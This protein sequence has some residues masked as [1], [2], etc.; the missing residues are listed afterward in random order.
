M[1]TR[2]IIAKKT[3]EGF[4]GTY[5]HWDGYPSVV[6]Q[7][8]AEGFKNGGWDYLNTVL[9]H[10]WSALW[11]NECHCCGTMSDGRREEIFPYTHETDCGAEYA[12]VFEHDT[13]KNTDFMH[14][15]QKKDSDGEHVVEFFGMTNEEGEWEISKTIDLRL[16]L[17]DFQELE[18]SLWET[19]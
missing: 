11:K 4:M 17:P 5:H 1:S 9:A 8:V 19:N 7:L 13:E 18:N 10:S 2:S 14:I 16:E 15:Y 3:P 12:Y 6:G